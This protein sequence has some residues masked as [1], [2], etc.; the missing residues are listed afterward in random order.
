MLIIGNST[1]ILKTYL[2]SLKS[3]F[4]Y[5]LLDNITITNIR[6]SQSIINIENE[7]NLENLN[8]K[9]YDIKQDL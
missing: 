2:L 3:I 7:E 9:E 5:L 4:Y 8:K 6:A 1:T